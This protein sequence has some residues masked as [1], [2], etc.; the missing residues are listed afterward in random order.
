MT[1]KPTKKPVV[2]NESTLEKDFQQTKKKIFS[3][4]VKANVF[5]FQLPLLIGVA[6]TTS[7]D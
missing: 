5:Q 2:P 7:D 6:S 3:V 1:V 4:F